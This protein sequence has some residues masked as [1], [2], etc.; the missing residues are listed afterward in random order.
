MVYLTK[1][2]FTLPNSDHNFHN[3][4]IS[5]LSSQGLSKENQVDLSASREEY[6]PKVGFIFNQ[7]Q[8]PKVSFLFSNNSSLL[9]DIENIT[10]ISRKSPHAYESIKLSDFI[11]RI[12]PY[13]LQ[14][15]DHV[16]FNLPYF[17]GIHPRILELRQQLKDT[18]LYHTF[19]KH[20]EDAPWDFILPGNREEIDRSVEIDYKTTRKPKIEI[21]S[22]D[23]SSTPLIQIDIQVDGRY[24]QLIKLFPEAIA[25]PEVKNLWVYIENIFGIDICFVVNETSS[26]DWSYHFAKER[27]S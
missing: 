16:G 6:Q 9:V 11:T 17:Q 8:I 24:E 23:K 14:G 12:S 22:F 27:L 3:E 26:E 21:V 4:F 13:T 1:V 19:P 2:L 10:H 5:Y 25:V 7:E 20:L 18:C 15:V